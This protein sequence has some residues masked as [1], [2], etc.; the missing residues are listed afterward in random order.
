ME[1]NLKD[2]F[3]QVFVGIP[4]VRSAYLARVSLGETVAPSVALCIRSSVGLDHP[5]QVRLGQIFTDMFSRDQHLD[6]LFVRDDQEQ[7][8]QQVCRPFYA[9]A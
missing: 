9:Q 7:E 3:R 1:D 4:S 5:L 6:I 8:L 2:W